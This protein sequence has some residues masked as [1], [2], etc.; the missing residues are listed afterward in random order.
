MGSHDTARELVEPIRTVVPVVT[1]T[2]TLRAPLPRDLSMMDG[3]PASHNENYVHSWL[4]D[5]VDAHQLLLD[6]ILCIATSDFGG[7]RVDLLLCDHV[8]G[9][10][11]WVLAPLPRALSLNFCRRYLLL[12]G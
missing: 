6:N 8:C 2:R 12:I 5:T 4:Q 9:S 3:P 7:A 11:L 1:G 10:H